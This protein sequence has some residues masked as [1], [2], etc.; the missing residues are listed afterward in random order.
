MGEYLDSSLGEDLV[1]L[2]VRAPRMSLLVWAE[3]SREAKG[4]KEWEERRASVGIEGVNIYHAFGF[5]LTRMSIHCT[6]KRDEVILT[7]FGQT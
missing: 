7:S 2:Q 3:E 4:R 6:F 1:D 5:L